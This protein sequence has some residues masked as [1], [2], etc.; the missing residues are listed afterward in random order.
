MGVV[1]VGARVRHGELVGE[2]RPRVDRGLRHARHAIHVVA[3]GDAV[4]VHAGGGGQLVVHLNPQKVTG[5]G[6]QQ[7]SWHRVAVRPGLDHATTEIDRGRAW[8]QLCGDHTLAG[9]ATHRLRTTHGPGGGRLCGRAPAGAHPGE[10]G[11]PKS[12]D[13]DVAT[14]QLWHAG[15]AFQKEPDRV[16]GG[17]RVSRPDTRS[18][19]IVL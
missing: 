6:P 4:P 10:T 5:A 13:E 2:L 8:R 11:E 19:M 15:L 17:L 7:R 12:S 1:E 3:Q 16:A 9:A 14:G 18:L